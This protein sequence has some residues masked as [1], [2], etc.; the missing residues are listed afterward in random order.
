MP[1]IVIHTDGACRNNP[2]P[3]G[4]GIVL[5]AGDRRREFSGAVPETTNNRME[6]L[7]AIRALER[8]KAASEVELYTDSSYLKNGITQWIHGW[9][10]KGWRTSSGSAVKNVD[11]WKRLHELDREHRIQWRWLKGHAGH[12]EN[13]RCDALAVQG[14]ERA[15]QGV[16]DEIEVDPARAPKAAPE[17]D[18][19]DPLAQKPGRN[20][21]LKL[22][23][24]DPAETRRRALALGAGPP[25]RLE[26]EDVYFAC[27]EGRLKLRGEKRPGRSTSE[28]IQYA[29]PDMA[30]ARLS[31]YSRLPQADP[32]GLRRMLA[33]SLGERGVV[34]KLRE[35]FL[36]GRTRLHL[37]RVR[38]LGDFAELELVLKEGESPKEARAELERLLEGLGLAAAE[39]EP[40][41]YIDLL[42]AGQ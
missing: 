25:A 18:A 10:R 23:I 16:T 42:L 27:R 22:R 24:T 30:Q 34:H 6:M 21:E 3:G 40:L 2:G 4:Y 1:P 7:A 41:S 12:A 31:C 15:A 5:R 9:I 28:L 36:L 20:L 39:I 32:D 35:L 33:A 11:L 17:K 38:G 14:V 8:L 29:R 19:T 13:E 26:Q 37:D